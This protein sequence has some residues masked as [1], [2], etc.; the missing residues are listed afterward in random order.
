MDLTR[1]TIEKILELKDPGSIEV[2]GKQL[3]KKGYA[4]ITAPL[5]DPIPTISLT[6]LCEFV[7]NSKNEDI[8]MVSVINERTVVVLGKLNNDGYRNRFC[9]AHIDWNNPGL[10]D[11]RNPEDFNIFIRANFVPTEDQNT[12]VDIVGQLK[13]EASE[14]WS[15]DGFSQTVVSKVGNAPAKKSV[16][17]PAA[18]RPYRTF[19]ELEQ[20]ES[21]F[22]VRMRKSPVEIRVFPAD[23]DLWRV[24][25][26]ENI[27]L[28]LSTNINGDIPI[29]G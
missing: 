9:R 7:N 17:N 16:P 15:D 12:L 8:E 13:L 4:E 27:K 28:F 26:I 22:I 20:P 25:A 23:G 3:V 24:K 21:I 29:I 18:L 19:P 10:D 2:N 1:E 14:E 5:A 11:W 6:G